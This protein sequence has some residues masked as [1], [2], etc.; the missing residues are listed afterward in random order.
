MR[1]FVIL[2]LGFI[3]TSCAS[4]PKPAECHGDFKPINANQSVKKLADV[5]CMMEKQHG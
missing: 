5:K 4:A 2:W 3:L 1:I